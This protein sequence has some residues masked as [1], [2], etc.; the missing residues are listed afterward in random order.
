MNWLLASNHVLSRLLVERTLGGIY[1]VAFLVTL[2]QFRPLCGEHGLL[3]NRQGQR[4]R[5]GHH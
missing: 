1:G 3:L 2:N 4:D 5:A